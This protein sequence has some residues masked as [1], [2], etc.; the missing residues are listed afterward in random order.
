MT[1]ALTEPAKLLL[2]TALLTADNI[3]S[4]NAKSFIKE[5][6]L[7]RDTR[8]DPLLQKFETEDAGSSGFLEKIHELI[9]DEAQALYSEVIC[10]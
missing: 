2:L 10:C 7:R 4:S 1:D 6:I 5:L 9:A 3:I 8:L